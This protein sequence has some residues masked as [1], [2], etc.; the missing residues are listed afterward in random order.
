MDGEEFQ[1]A[2]DE[3]Q[4]WMGVRLGVIAVGQGE[5]DGRP[6]IDVWVTSPPPPDRFPQQLRGFPVVLRDSGGQ[7]R[8]QGT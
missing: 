5:V 2:L 1:R 4:S 7:I 6:A 3:A 8:A